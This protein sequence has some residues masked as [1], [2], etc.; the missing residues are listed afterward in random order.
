MKIVRIIYEWPPP[1]L[2][3]SPVS[4]ELT[5][6][7]VGLGHEVDVFCARWPNSGPIEELKGARLH[8]VWRA[9]IQGS[10]IITSSILLFFKYLFWQRPS[11]PDVIHS[12]GHFAIWIY[13]YRLFLDKFFPWANELK[14]P[15]VVHFHNTVMGR[16][17]KLKSE[18]KKINPISQFLD[19]PLGVFSDKLAIKV[20]AAYVFVSEELKNEAIKYYKADAKKCFVIE[21]G[22]NP[23]LFTSVTLEEREKSR[24]EL[25][26]ELSDKVILY[27]GNLVERKNVDV[28]YEALLHLPQHYKLLVVGAD[29]P[30][31]FMIKLA[32]IV[33]KNKAV[34]DERIIRIKTTPY[35]QIPIAYQLSDIFVLPS[36]WEG[37]PKVVM[38]ALACKLPVLASGF[39]VIDDVKGLEYLKELDPEYLA[40]KIQDMI[41]NPR[42]VDLYNIVHNHSWDTKARQIESV[43]KFAQE[44]H[45]Q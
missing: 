21:S 22:V 42:E 43:Y 38:E 18:N 20:G 45:M 27:V 13:M 32:E 3:L 31:D 30:E 35:P 28:L 15:L 24:K 11:R 33:E 29:G 16:W 23:K 12:H 41:L 2:P 37:L 39:K 9:P 17:E 10:V 44:T 34:L 8:P 36:S 26:Y 25:G 6:S 1:W 14:T 40:K 7:Q 5:K 4:Y 19:W